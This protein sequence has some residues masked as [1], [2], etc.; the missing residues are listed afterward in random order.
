MYSHESYDDAY[1]DGLLGM[2]FLSA[3]QMTVDY[4]NSRIHLKR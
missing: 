1:F 2:S 3:F 4:K